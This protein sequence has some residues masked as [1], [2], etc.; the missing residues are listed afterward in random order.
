MAALIWPLAGSVIA[1]LLYYP[2]HGLSVLV[3]FCQLPGN[4]VAVGT[5]C[6]QLLAIYGLISLASTL[7]AAALVVSGFIAVA[8][9]L[10]PIWQTQATLFRATVLRQQQ[11]QFVQDQGRYY[12]LIVE[13][14]I[15]PVLQFYLFCSSRV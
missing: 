7:V 4:S 14:P 12:W 6:L 10:I 15:P 3:D 11:N 8:L 9:V 2:T 5:I 13:L 1:W